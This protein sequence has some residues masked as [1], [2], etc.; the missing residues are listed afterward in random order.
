[1]LD[2]GTLALSS[3]P[4]RDAS[5]KHFANFQSIWRQ[6]SPGVW[7]V[8]FDRGERVCDCAPK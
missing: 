7:R 3:G 5:G 2:S 4:V 1:V 6:E 8:V